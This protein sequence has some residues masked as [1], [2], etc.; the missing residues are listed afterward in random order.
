MK[1][2]YGVYCKAGNSDPKLI[3]S[4]G[5]QHIPVRTRRKYAGR[6]AKIKAIEQLTGNVLDAHLSTSEIN[7]Y[8]GQYIFGTSQWAEYHRLF[9]Y[10]ASELEQVPEPVELKF[11]VI[12]EFDEAMCRPDDD[13]L[14]Y[15]VKQALENNSIDIYRGLQNP[16]ITFF[17]QAIDNK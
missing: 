11:H 8:I 13:R 3:V 12:V 17:I 2:K 4:Y 5:E 9:E 16:I 10:F 15:M 7:A 1:V 6:K 14:I